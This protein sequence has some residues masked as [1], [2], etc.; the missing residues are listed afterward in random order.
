MS[1]VIDLTRHIVMT[2]DYS[3]GLARFKV[4]GCLYT[5]AYCLGL[6]SSHSIGSEDCSDPCVGCVASEECAPRR[7]H[8]YRGALTLVMSQARQLLDDPAHEILDLV[9]LSIRERSAT[10]RADEGSDHWRAR[11]Y[12]IVKLEVLA[13]L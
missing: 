2:R 7:F 4:P 5:D 3:F 10:W 9:A 6:A 11:V 1:H 12:L 13:P 8:S